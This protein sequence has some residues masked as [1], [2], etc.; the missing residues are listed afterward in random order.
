[1]VTLIGDVATNYVQMR[2]TQEQIALSKQNVKLQ[3]NILRIVQARLDAGSATELDVDQAQATLFQTMS[4]I[5]AFEVVLRQSQNAICMLLGM[6]PTDLQSQL[7]ERPIPAAPVEAVVGI[8]A[9]LL[10]RRPDIRSAERAAAAQS[11]QIGIAQSDW[12]PH[13]SILGTLGYATTGQGLS[14]LFTP[15]N[16]VGSVGPSF[17]W[18]ILEYGRILGNVHLQD[19]QFQAALLNYR[20]TVLNA[21]Q[22]A[23]NG[24]VTYVRARARR[25]SCGT[26]S[27]RPARLTASW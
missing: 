24:L 11:E 18:N 4:T 12:Y 16:Q 2:Q 13:I 27:S 15:A 26:A 19:A 6:P 14:H 9:Q 10:E 8:P 25:G 21:N 7:S 17:Q 20:A 5:P 1:M 22:E 3:Q 23:E